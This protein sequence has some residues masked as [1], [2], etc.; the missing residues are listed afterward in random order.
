[1][2]HNATTTATGILAA[3]R[4]QA[5]RLYWPI[6]TNDWRDL[7]GQAKPLR[8]PALGLGYGILEISKQLAI[9]KYRVIIPSEIPIISF[10]IFCP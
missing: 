8:S 1:M 6:E 7:M 5:T 4:D 9:I 10:V 3:R 2:R